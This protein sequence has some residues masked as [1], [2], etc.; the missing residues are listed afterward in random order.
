VLC[1][2]A[3]SAAGPI[4]F[5]ALAVPHAARRL[6]GP[7]HAWLLP[8]CALLGAVFLMLADIVGRVVARP[9]EL[10]VGVMTALLGAPVL[11]HLVRRSR[12][13]G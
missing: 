3:V 1:G 9:A 12:A 13:T 10:E 5:V 6:V 8:A 4:A 7:S 2:V 11:V